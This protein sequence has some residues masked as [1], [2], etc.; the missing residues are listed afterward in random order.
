[1]YLL[2]NNNESAPKVGEK[3]PDLDI[4]WYSGQDGNMHDRDAIHVR[5]AW[6]QAPRHVKLIHVI[7]LVEITC[8]TIQCLS[9]MLVLS[10]KHSFIS[11]SEFNQTKQ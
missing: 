8:N 9:P 3:G 4:A 5:Y 11:H 1:M 7:S 2:L 6:Q 10:L